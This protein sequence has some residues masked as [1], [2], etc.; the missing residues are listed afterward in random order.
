MLVGQ[1]IL[2]IIQYLILYMYSFLFFFFCKFHLAGW[3]RWVVTIALFISNV[4]G[5]SSQGQISE[6]GYWT[7]LFLY[8]PLCLH[9]PFT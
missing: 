8:V 4:S 7:D 3:G 6:R 9:L 2:T 1:N 5:I